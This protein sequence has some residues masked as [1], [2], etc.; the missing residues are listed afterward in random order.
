MN[1][2]ATLAAGLLALLS[3]VALAQQGEEVASESLPLAPAAL[4]EEKKPPPQCAPPEFGQVVVGKRV[5]E[6][7]FLSDRSMSVLKQENLQQC[8]PR[9]TPE[10]LWDAPGVFVQQTNHGGGAPILRGMIGPQNLILVD[11]VRLNNSTFRTGPIQYLNL[12]DPLSLDRL[13]VLRGP[14]SVLYGSDAMGGVVQAFPLA[15]RDF[16]ASQGVDGGAHALLSYASAN[17]G[18]ALHAHGDLG[19]GG[20][21]AL[22]GVTYRLLDDLSGGR[23]IGEQPHSGYDN[24]AS[25]GRVTYRL[26]GDTFAGWSVSAAYLVSRI[27]GAGRTDKLW[28]KHSL[29]IYDNDDHLLYGRLHMRIAPLSTSGDLTIS[30]QHM[31]ERK[32]NITVGDDY[33]TEVKTTRDETTVDTLGLDL[34]LITRLK[35]YRLR[36]LYG[37]MFYRDWVGALRQKRTIGSAWNDSAEANYPSG[38]TY[39]NYGGFLMLEWDPLHSE[40]GHVLRLGAGYRLHGMAG[41]GPATSSLPEVNISDLGHVFLGSVKYMYQEKGVVAF[42]FSQGFRAPN[43]NEAVMLGDTGKFFHIPNDGLS[44]ERLDTLELLARGK[45]WRITAG[46]SGYVSFLHDLI[47]REKITDAATLKRWIPEA[48]GKDIWWNINGGDGLLWGVEGQ[49]GMDLGLGLSL[50][51]SITQT[52]GEEHGTGGAEDIPLSRIPPLYGQ[53][54]LRYDTRQYSAWAG[55]I[56]TYVRAA[57]PQERLSKEDE[58]DTRIPAGGTPGWWTWNVRA[59]A[60][61]LDHLRL[62]LEVE[63]LLDADYKLH[64]S[65]V[66]GAGTNAKLTLEGY[67]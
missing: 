53:I 11:G 5:P 18:R 35:K 58:A 10:A 13:E 26:P 8:G 29:Q 57:A 39:D 46:L 1:L 65:G 20:F 52:W 47:K 62:G 12:L 17:K 61:I 60:T 27:M 22:A 64:G 4:D 30:F 7:P 54:K 38:S 41:N 14:G 2:K 37:G 51:G 23:G 33:I 9:T 42:T 15:A 50:A 32:D 49:L 31:F 43:L 19:Y 34:Q 67:F 24:W 21:S 6:P 25:L 16:R 3:Q 45:L 66:Y 56:E 28:D 40:A 63:N 44:P 59:G 55:F 48:G 36:F